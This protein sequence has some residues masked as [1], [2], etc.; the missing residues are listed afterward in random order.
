MQAYGPGCNVTKYEEGK[1]IKDEWK[2]VL[3]GKDD[4]NSGEQKNKGI[5]VTWRGPALTPEGKI[6][7]CPQF[8][9][10]NK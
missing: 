2:G 4:E 9:K 7:G 8:G 5:D 3:K 1:I 6:A 10:Y